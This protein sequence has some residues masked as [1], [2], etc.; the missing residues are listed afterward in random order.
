MI[1]YTGIALGVLVFIHELGH[2]LAAKLTGMRVDRFSLGFPP[3]AFGKKVGDTDY[4]I[5]WLPLG[6]YVKIA[7]MIDESFDTDFLSR[8]PEPWEFRA[9][10][11]WARMLV[12]SAGVIMNVLLA[13]FIFTG[14]NFTHGRLIERTTE[15]GIVVPGT[16]ATQVGLQPGDKI[17]SV[18]G[19]PVSHW[20]QIQDFIYL[21]NFGKDITLVIERAN[22]QKQIFIPRSLIPENATQ[23]FGVIEAHTV[24]MVGSVE[25]GMPGDKA[26]LKPGDIIVSIADV[27][28]TY[29]SNVIKA[30]RA[31]AGKPLNIS[32]KRGEQEFSATAT[33]TDSGKLQIGINNYYMGPADT[34]RFSM[35]EAFVAGVDNVLESTI[36]F[37]KSIGQIIVGKASFREN[38]GG[39][40]AIAQLATKSAESGITSFLS[41]VALLSMS[42]AVLNILPFPVLDGGHLAMMI[43]EKIFGKEIPPR[44]KLGIQKAG[45]IILLAFM[46]FVIYNDISR[47]KF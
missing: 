31:H 13:T 10:P 23:R 14:I 19:E 47:S 39:P 15:I 2:F 22:E 37:Y 20:G 28:V 21:D 35:F 16:P 41:F 32:W 43:A 30:V 1:L 4:C 18:N 25:K 33:P 42:L 26:G 29:D 46:A 34:V 40:Y 7:G 38:I 17:L 12:I 8:S 3:R 27:P 45:F 5:S 44:V 6:G 9:K 24:V 36:L 11:L